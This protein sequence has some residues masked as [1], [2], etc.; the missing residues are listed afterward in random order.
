MAKAEMKTVKKVR[1]DQPGNAAGDKQV[2]GDVSLPAARRCSK[3]GVTMEL[4]TEGN[5]QY[6]KCPTCGET[7][8][9][10]AV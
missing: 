9:I 5:R 6:W 4:I 7:I 1:N 2:Q 8:E 3:C 10:P